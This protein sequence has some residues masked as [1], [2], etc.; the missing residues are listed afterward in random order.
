[1]PSPSFLDTLTWAQ[2]EKKLASLNKKEKGDYFERLTK[3]YFKIDPKLQS[4][5][6]EVWLL[7]ELPT[8]E[9]EFLG[10]PSHDLGIDLIGKKGTEYHAIQCKCKSSAKSGLR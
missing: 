8:R 1:M 5:Y 4:F 9:R 2:F 7:S 10:I 3:Y 6:D